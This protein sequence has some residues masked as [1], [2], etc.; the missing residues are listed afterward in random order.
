MRP[1]DTGDEALWFLV[2]GDSEA[3]PYFAVV[4]KQGRY[5]VD[6]DGLRASS[7]DPLSSEL[8]GLGLAGLTDSV[9]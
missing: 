1:L 4:N 5:V 7:D 8:A 6:G 3:M 9:E 2:V